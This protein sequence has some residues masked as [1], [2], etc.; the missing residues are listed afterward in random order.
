MEKYLNEKAKQKYDQIIE[1]V[2][3]KC[4]NRNKCIMDQIKYSDAIDIN[5][6]GLNGFI[7]RFWVEDKRKVLILFSKNNRHEFR[8]ISD[9]IPHIPV[10]YVTKDKKGVYFGK[11]NLTELTKGGN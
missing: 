1:Y 3:E 7:F 11:C 5:F 10:F 2:N 6:D 8:D 9:C 4:P